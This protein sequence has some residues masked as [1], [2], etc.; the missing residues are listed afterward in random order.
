MSKRIIISDEEKN[1]ILEMHNS[2]KNKIFEQSG[3]REDVE[4]KKAKQLFLNTK[5]KINLP[6]DGN[7]NSKESKDAIEKYQRMINTTVDGTWNDR[8]IV[9]MSQEDKNLY[10]KL[11]PTV[12]SIITKISQGISNVF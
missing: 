9:G 8:Y 11:K 4:N 1:S 10:E 5:L 3:S 6:L 7:L 12:Q 2:L